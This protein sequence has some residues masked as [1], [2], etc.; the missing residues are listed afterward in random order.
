M[1]D[2]LIREPKFG[3]FR[4]A[5]VGGH[6]RVV[7]RRTESETSGVQHLPP[8]LESKGASRSDL[9]A[10]SLGLQIRRDRLATDRRM[11]EATEPRIT[12]MQKVLGAIVAAFTCTHTSNERDVVVMKGGTTEVRTVRKGD[13]D[14]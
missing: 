11:L 9:P 3:A 4:K 1:T 6:D 2:E 13:E 8:A 5:V 12:R 7:V 14:D 10:E